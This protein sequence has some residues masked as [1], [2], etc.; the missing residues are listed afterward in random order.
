MP[1]LVSDTKP[2]S[3]SQDASGQ[4]VVVSK[5]SS[6]STSDSPTVVSFTRLLAPTYET[7][8]TPLQLELAVNQVTPD[9][10]FVASSGAVL[11]TNFLRF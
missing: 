3:V 6:S 9:L 4:L 10:S 7:T 2:A 5:L 11:L 1:E 8:A